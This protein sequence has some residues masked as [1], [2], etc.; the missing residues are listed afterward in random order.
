[1]SVVA[2]TCELCAVF[3]APVGLNLVQVQVSLSRPLPIVQRS[4]SDSAVV[5]MYVYEPPARAATARYD[6]DPGTQRSSARAPE[7]APTYAVMRVRPA[8]CRVGV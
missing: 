1:M 4:E 7:T 8:K 3:I 6:R 5:C 2:S